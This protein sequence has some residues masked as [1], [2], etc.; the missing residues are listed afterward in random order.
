[1]LFGR[2]PIVIPYNS[3]FPDTKKGPEWTPN[4]VNI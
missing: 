4:T 2:M 3:T 1:M